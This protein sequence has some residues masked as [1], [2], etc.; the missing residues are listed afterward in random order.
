MHRSILD[1]SVATKRNTRLTRSLSKQPSQTVSS[2]TRTSG[3]SL[4]TSTEV[5]S[6]ISMSPDDESLPNNNT[7]A[8]D[9]FLS[10]CPAPPL[11]THSSSTV[12]APLSEDSDSDLEFSSTY[13]HKFP[14]S[15]LPLNPS[16]LATS[17]YP[18]LAQPPL[19][20]EG[21]ITPKELL[22]FEQDC[23]SYFINAKGRVAMDQ[24]VPRIL[25]FFR[26]KH[27]R[28][29][30]TTN[31]SNLLTLDFDDFMKQLRSEFLP[32]N[33]EEKVHAKILGSKM[34][35]SDRFIMWARGLQA[36]NYMLQGTSSHLSDVTH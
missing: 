13:I 6:A 2:P 18:A 24:M 14:M 4:P 12:V 27:V 10:R 20:L 33:W 7:P 34:P 3:S 21:E 23:Q 28:N 5:H 22:T 19:F 11:Q 1:P 36:E 8:P 35:K 26:D 31:R 25:N 32:K 9:F 15:S 16:G 17:F 29:W 30:I